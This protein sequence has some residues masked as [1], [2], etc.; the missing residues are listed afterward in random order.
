MSNCESGTAET[1]EEC[2]KMERDG[3]QMLLMK[4]L[5]VRATRFDVCI[6]L[7]VFVCMSRVTTSGRERRKQVV[8][9][10]TR[11]NVSRLWL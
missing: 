3:M 2:G 10:E 11:K 6:S 1:G 9:S 8:G 4:R 7:R 5:G